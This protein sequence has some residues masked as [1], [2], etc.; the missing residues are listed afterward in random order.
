MSLDLTFHGAAGCVTGF[1]AKLSTERATGKVGFVRVGAKGD[2]MPTIEG[3]SSRGAVE[4]ATAY[5]DHYA[6][7][8]GARASELTQSAVA[9]NPYGW[10]ISYTQS[11]KG[12]PVF[13]AVLK[14]NVDKAQAQVVPRGSGRLSGAGPWRIRAAV[15]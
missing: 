14:A 6:P 4:K 1:C 10:T 11:Y 8:F 7:A 2:L 15:S 12:V 9:A 3:D 13:G 5:L